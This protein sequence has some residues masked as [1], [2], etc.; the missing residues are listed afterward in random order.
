MLRN[1]RYVT[2]SLPFSQNHNKQWLNF[3]GDIGVGGQT[4]EKTS[5]ETG[6]IAALVRSF[7]MNNA[8]IGAMAVNVII[9]LAQTVMMCTHNFLQKVTQLDKSEL[10]AIKMQN[11]SG[12][13]PS[14]RIFNASPYVIP[15]LP[16]AI[17]K[18]THT[19]NFKSLLIN[20]NDYQFELSAPHNNRWRYSYL[21]VIR[22]GE[23][24]L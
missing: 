18:L 10:I 8:Q 4:K 7:G 1:Q 9:F 6:F 3:Q 5:M 21:S 13:Y 20:P 23:S 19:L 14:P 24:S 11:L 15:N 17:R 2:F 22:E 16:E 12:K